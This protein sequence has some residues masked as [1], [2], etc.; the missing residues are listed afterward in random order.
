MGC[1]CPDEDVRTR[2]EQAMRKNV[3]RTDRALRV[4]VA[5]GAVAGGAV[6]GFSTAGGIVLLVV[7][8][9]M[10]LTA[11]SGYCPLYR[12]LRIATTA[13]GDAEVARGRGLHLHRAA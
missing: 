11:A 9:V 4:V 7:T 5:A 6:L 3:G 1:R 10:A 2:K 12:L 8:A 13:T